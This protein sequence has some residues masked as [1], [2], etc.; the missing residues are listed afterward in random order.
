M[1]FVH[2]KK[3]PEFLVANNNIL[4]KYTFINSINEF[5]KGTDCEFIAKS[6]LFSDNR[7]FDLTSEGFAIDPFGRFIL[8]CDTANNRII[9]YSINFEYI[10]EKIDATY[11]NGCC[12]AAITSDGRYALICAKDG[13]LVT[14]IYTDTFEIINCGGT[15]T[16]GSGNNQLN[17]PWGIDITP[18]D[19]YYIVV[20]RANHRI[21]KHLVS[22]HDYVTKIGSWGTGDSEFDLPLGCCIDKT[23]TYVI[24][25][26]YNNNRIKKH[27]VSDL[28]YVSK[29]GS[30][31]SGDDEFYAPKGCCI[32][33]DN[34]Y[35]IVTDS[36]NHRLKWHHL[37]DLSFGFEF[38]S[39]G[40]GDDE[41]SNP[42]QP[43][44][45]KN[46]VFIDDKS[47]Q[48]IV[49]RIGTDWIHQ[50]FELV[51]T[52]NSAGIYSLNNPKFA[53]FS[54]D[55]QFV[56]L[57]DYLGNKIFKLNNK[58]LEFLQVESFTRPIYCK[59]DGEY[60]YLIENG[61]IEK[62]DLTTLGILATNED[63]YYS[64]DDYAKFEFTPEDDYIITQIGNAFNKLSK[65]DLT[66]VA[67]GSTY[68]EASDY[69]FFSDTQFYVFNPA[70][71]GTIDIF[72]LSTLNRT[73]TAYKTWADLRLTTPRKAI[74]YKL[75]DLI[76][77]SD[78]NDSTVKVYDSALNFLFD[79]GVWIDS[80]FNGVMG[81]DIEQNYGVYGQTKLN[82]NV[83]TL[84]SNYFY[85]KLLVYLPDFVVINGIL[86]AILKGFQAIFKEIKEQINA[87]VLK[88]LV[89]YKYQGKPLQQNTIEKRLYL[90][91]ISDEWEWQY[92]LERHLGINQLRGSK[93]GLEEDLLRILGSTATITITEIEP[94]QS[95]WYLDVSYPEIYGASVDDLAPASFLTCVD[96]V[97]LELENTNTYNKK[98]IEN[99][100]LTRLLPGNVSPII[101]WS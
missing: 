78:Y 9:K 49:K 65:T 19:V 53:T 90:K 42:C 95:G 18:D 79:W 54:R 17:L 34:E 30:A 36:S 15:G 24:I 64:D 41:F 21:K 40:S 13:H 80:N 98:V 31:G 23:G 77:I 8:F 84:D 62:L 76:F 5:Y 56:Y 10:A 75:L 2:Y 1:S 44:T 89:N 71:S 68:Y 63:I 70:G 6:T 12:A 99:I 51:Q 59:D 92:L 26:D 72:N 85:N 48:R 96:Q 52:I 45:Y 91:G 100:I 20:D 47:N 87:N 38:G 55:L 3:N 94:D 35:I 50:K 67:N 82:A 22:N 97:L 33:N 57:C 46:F 27:Q 4:S 86:T 25:S 7:D 74:Y 37:D 66:S 69:L 81:I 83:L 28:G 43:K 93:V 11:F 58:N 88:A 39:S 29:I 16:S 101:V 32:T 73:T 60:L 14:K 61:K